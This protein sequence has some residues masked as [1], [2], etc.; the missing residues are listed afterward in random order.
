MGLMKKIV[1]I[2]SLLAIVAGCADEKIQL[3]DAEQLE[4]D[5]AIIDKWLADNGIT[6]LSDASGLRYVITATGTGA[7]PKLTNSVTVKY[8]GK[9]LKD[10]ILPSQS[11]VRFATV[12]SLVRLR[13]CRNLS[14]MHTY[15]CTILRCCYLINSRAAK[16]AATRRQTRQSGRG[17]AAK[18]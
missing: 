11:V 17:M 9:F 18:E 12:H 7:K 13:R 16:L 4:K 5:I 1:L 3:S 6:A 2:F 8:T 15:H 14:H 10:G